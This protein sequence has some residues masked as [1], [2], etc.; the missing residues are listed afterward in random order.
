MDN[1]RTFHRRMPRLCWVVLVAGILLIMPG[2][3]LT[4]LGIGNVSQYTAAAASPDEAG[5]AVPLIQ[6]DGF[7]ITL[8]ADRTAKPDQTDSKPE[9]GAPPKI[10]KTSPEIRARTWIQP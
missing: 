5:G 1:Q 7:L 3:G 6:A 9:P 8:Q 2:A 4:F 10:V